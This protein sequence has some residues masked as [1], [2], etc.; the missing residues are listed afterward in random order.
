MSLPLSGPLSFSEIAS[1]VGVGSP[2]SLNTM[3]A[4]A[5]FGSPDSVSEF[6]G[7]GPGGL[8]LFYR[9][10]DYGFN[11]NEQCFN[12][13]NTEVYHNGVNPLPS[14]GDTVYEDPGGNFPIQPGGVYW[15]MSE[16]QY[17]PAFIT[18]STIS[19]SQGVVDTLGL[20]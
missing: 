19:K 20:C 15:G 9:T 12:N 10:F 3:S 4:N 6:Y 16:I 8:I 17:E 18:F 2:Y 13:C 11:P 5:G 7:Y 14:P 1:V